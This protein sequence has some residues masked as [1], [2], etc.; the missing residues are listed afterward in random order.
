MSGKEKDLAGNVQGGMCPALIGS[1]VYDLLVAHV[2]DR[3]L[4]L[5]SCSVLTWTSASVLTP[6]GLAPSAS[7]VREDTTVSAPSAFRVTRT[8]AAAARWVGCLVWWGF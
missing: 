7:I 8:H 1:T 4:M 2:H 5:F 3:L 6:A